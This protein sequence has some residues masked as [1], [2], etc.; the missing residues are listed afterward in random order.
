MQDITN[1]RLP[2]PYKDPRTQ[3]YTDVG[4][5]AVS[6]PREPLTCAFSP[7]HSPYGQ[8]CAI[9]PCGPAL[10]GPFQRTLDQ[11]VRLT[12]IPQKE[13]LLGIRAGTDSS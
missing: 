12:V 6:L 11:V 9:S 3:P 5:H 4:G 13:P 8:L 10:H 2:N 7:A 1:E